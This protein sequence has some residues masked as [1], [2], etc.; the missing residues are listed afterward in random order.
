MLA[1]AT[2]A[3]RATPV[4]AQTPELDA[5]WNELRPVLENIHGVAT[6]P[7]QHVVQNHFTDGMLLGN[8]DLGV[9]VGGTVSEQ[10]FYFGKGD[11]W[12][13]HWEPRHSALLPSI[14]SLGGLTISS[15]EPGDHPEKPYRM[16]QDILNAEVDTT[17][18]LGGATVQ[19]RSWTADRD[20]VFVT[21]ISSDRGNSPVTLH[22][23]LWMPPDVPENHT[24]YPFTVGSDQKLIWAT[25]ENN[26]TGAGEFKAR[27]AVAVAIVGG[28]F[29]HVGVAMDG[30]VGGDF[31]LAGGSKVQL[32]TVFRSNA[33]I[34]PGG[35][36]A[37]AL[38]DLA[39]ERA[40]SISSD[41]VADLQRDHREWWKRYWLKSYV[42]VYDDVLEKYY[43]GSLYMMACASRP[44]KLPPGIWASW[45][46]N[47][48][49]SWG[50]RYFLNYNFEAPFYGVFSSNRPELAE[51]YVREIMAELPWAENAAAVAGYQGACYQR[52][53]PPF[54][55][56]APAPAR[57]PIAPKKDYTKLPATADQKSNGSFAAMPAIWYY[58]YTGDKDYLRTTLY[59][60]LKSLDA[61]WR[62]YLIWDPAT[63]RYVIT[64]S[65]AHEGGDDINPNLDLG[66]IRQIDRTL[67]ETSKV[68]GVDED[69][70]PKWQDVLD[71]LSAYPT[72]IVNGKR[73]FYIA[74][75]VDYHS[76]RPGRKFEPG[77][78]P[79]NMEGT[80]FPGENLSIGGDADLLAIA[81]N[82]I[83]EMNSWGVTPGGNL[84]NGFCKE[85]PVAARVGWPAGDLVKRF[86]AAIQ[87]Q[88]R[89]TNLTVAQGGGGIETSGSIEALDSMLMQSEAGVVRLFP[90]W[91]ADMPA[92]FKRLRAKGAFVVS[93][94]W[95]DGKVDN[96]DVTSER[97]NPLVVSN[98]WPGHSPSVTRVD[99]STMKALETVKCTTADGNIRF[100]T[101]S[102]ERY[103]ISP[104]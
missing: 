51:P 80:V 87:F 24:V 38:K 71:K 77:G 76:G 2:L 67:I 63:K 100:D 14:L 93:S 61:F 56:F 39:M 31:Q 25:R 102:G 22:A 8:G 37:E 97:G 16:T 72:G 82:S 55:L 3:M 46:T 10:K 92:S 98:P 5:D 58:E 19:M 70:R 91:P 40:G 20:N 66:F 34:G 96:I 62:D 28:A 89:G 90:N 45:V 32:V 29:S 1:I 50:G 17:M 18:R 57:E 27:C 74:E 85:F 42:R 36:D 12:G 11:F 79:I 65:S 30:R 88:W 48:F 75:D 73:V 7:P 99:A 69:L 49:T 64:H 104:H 47:D 41:E 59:P 33:R 21:E 26:L 95:K 43:Y 68:L 6:T 54:H 44:G 53:F 86:K 103:L 84:H 60:L 83:E 94:A 78:Q 13:S 35:P 81:K 23:E 4:H 15:P 101:T 52:T 9:V